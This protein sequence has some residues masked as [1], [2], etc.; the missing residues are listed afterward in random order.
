MGGPNPSCCIGSIAGSRAAAASWGSDRVDLFSLGLDHGLWQN[1]WTSETGYSGWVTD[2]GY[3][4]SAEFIGDPAAFSRATNYIDVFMR[5]N[6]GDIYTETWNGSTWS[7]WT[8]I[9]SCPPGNASSPSVASWSSTNLQVYERGRDGNIYQIVWNGTSWGSWTSIGA[10]AVGAVSDPSA[11]SRVSNW[12][13]VFTRGADGKIYSTY[14]N[15]T[16]WSSWTSF[17]EP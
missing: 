13:D 1:T 5:G 3:P 10:P 2:L 7:G 11:Y 17:G 16:S 9:G 8:D 12:A 14:W 15:G 6:N 4:T